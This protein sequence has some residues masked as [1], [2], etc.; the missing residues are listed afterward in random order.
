MRYR[1]LSEYGVLRDFESEKLILLLDDMD[2][3]CP[4]PRGCF[5]GM[6]SFDDTADNSKYIFRYHG[7]YVKFQVL[8]LQ[9]LSKLTPY[10]LN[11]RRKK[12]CEVK[13]Q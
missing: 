12:P 5:F 13:L 10:Q 7:Y 3:L 11:R 9:K 6:I 2:A 4:M 1:L 8:I